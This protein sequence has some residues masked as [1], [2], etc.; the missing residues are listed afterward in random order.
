MADSDL[1]TRVHSQ[2]DG[3]DGRVQSKVVGADSATLGVGAAFQ[4][5]VD[6]DGNAHVEIHGDQSGTTNDVKLRLTE[7]G[8]INPDGVYHVADN[9]DPGN[10]GLVAMARNVTPADAQ[11]TERLTSVPNSDG[12]VR[13]LDISLHDEDGEPYT[14]T[15]PIPVAISESE[16]TEVHDYDDSG[17]DVASGGVDNHDYAVGPDTTFY[18]HKVL[19]DASGDAKWELQIGDGATPTEGFVTKAVKFTSNAKGQDIELLKAIEVT[20][21]AGVTRTVRVIRTNRD[22]KPQPVYSTIIGI[23][24]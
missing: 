17:G 3:T 11:Q 1:G 21:G 12:S 24:G 14:I 22:N 7:L 15:N 4:Q 16:G 5:R 13:S 23:I 19:C 10:I 18:L 6:A 9:T 8:A 2:V 20:S